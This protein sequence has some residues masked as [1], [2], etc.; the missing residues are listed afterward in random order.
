[1]H[2]SRAE[3]VDS[4]SAPSRAMVDSKSISGASPWAMPDPVAYRGFWN[5]LCLLFASCPPRSSASESLD[6]DSGMSRL[7]SDV[8]NKGFAKKDILLPADFI[9]IVL[10]LSLPEDENIGFIK[11]MLCCLCPNMFGESWPTCE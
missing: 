1:M 7:S 9:A 3:K 11:S 2:S 8:S 4:N 5:P 6:G 10:F